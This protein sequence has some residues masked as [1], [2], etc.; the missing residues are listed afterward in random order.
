M[1]AMLDAEDSS[2]LRRTKLYL[3]RS[4]AIQFLLDTK[5]TKNQDKK[6]FSAQASSRPG[7]LSGICAL[8]KALVISTAGRN[9]LRYA[10]FAVQVLEDFSLRSK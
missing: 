4:S 6:T 9:L 5:V 8:F 2:F 3:L 7:F 1:L 10:K